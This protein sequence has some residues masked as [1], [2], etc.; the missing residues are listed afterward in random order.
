VRVLED[1]FV[2]SDAQAYQQDIASCVGE[3]SNHLPTASVQDHSDNFS[4]IAG[5]SEEFEEDIVI[6]EREREKWIKLIFLL[7]ELSPH[8]NFWSREIASLP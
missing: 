2:C 5:D 7:L 8:I 4:S 6:G 1:V 3:A